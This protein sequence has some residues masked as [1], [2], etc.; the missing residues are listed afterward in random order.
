MKTLDKDL[1]DTLADDAGAAVALV[2]QQKLETAG[3]DRVLFPPTFAG[4][5]YQNTGY[6]ID[7][8]SDGTLCALVDTVG[9]QVNRMEA[10]FVGDEPSG[11]GMYVPQIYITI[12][13]KSATG[14]SITQ[15]V[16]VMQ[17]GH[18]LGDALVRSSA[19]GAESQAAFQSLLERGDYGPIAKLSPTTLV[20]GAWDSRD[21]QAK[22]PRIV[23]STVRAWDVD[24]LKRSAQYTPPIDYAKFN[25][26]EESDIEKA[27]QEASSGGTKNP[28]AQRGYV[29][30]PATDTHG[31]VRVN[32][33]ITRDIVVNLVALRH[34]ESDKQPELRRYVLGLSLAA[35]AYPLDGAYRQGCLLIPSQEPS[36]WQ[37]VNRDGT[38]EDISI[39]LEVLRGY[40]EPLSSPYLTKPQMVP[41]DPEKAKADKADK[42][43]KASKKKAKADKAS[44][45][46]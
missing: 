23:Q 27:E 11:L 46:K 12:E 42:A 31:G 8:L 38:R 7:K 43:D 3:L 26:F 10:L 40:L 29:P 2:R 6:V 1:L 34:I 5:G 18:R 39:D 45:K 32:G 36:P 30:V 9:S 33:S 16:S 14:E 17:A 44:K 37:L 20:F 22:L 41:F 24:V 28:L 19:M 25:V 21:T 15:E 4:N 13:R 35:A